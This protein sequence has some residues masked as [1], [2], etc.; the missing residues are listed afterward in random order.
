MA[1]D[2]ISIGAMLL[3]AVIQQKTQAD[4]IAKQKRMA[5]ESQQR[6]LASQNQ[7]TDAAMKRVQEFDP[8][9][10]KQAQDAI[11]QDLTQ[12]LEQA[13]T[14]RPITAQG[15][16]VGGTI[17]GGTSDYLTAKAKETAKAAES[18]RQL[19]QLFGRIGGAQQLRRNESV[20]FGDTAGE[21]GRIQTG[22]NNVANIDQI[23]IDAAGQPSLGGMLVSSALGAYGMGRASL[24]G[25]TKMKPGAPGGFGGGSWLVGPQ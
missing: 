10:R 6:A 11:T 24:P 7:A 19:A 9:T 12:Q 22:A 13:G 21:I 8:N 23:G 3:S 16:E 2:P 15:V 18:S 4:A 14:A 1:F 5:V 17:P 20:A 25:A